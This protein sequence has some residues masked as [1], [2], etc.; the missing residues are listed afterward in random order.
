[1]QVFKSTA[2]VR[3][4]K[5]IAAT[6]SSARILDLHALA[7]E[8]PEDPDYLESPLFLHP[9][10]NRSIIVKHNLGSDEDDRSG[11][12]RF[13]ATKVIFPFDQSDL[14]LGGQ[15]LIVD[16]RD[17]I[18]ALTRH[19]DYSTLSLDRDLAVL[20]AVD[21]LPTL[22]P[23]LVREILNQHQIEVGRCYYRFSQCDK[24]QMLDFVANEIE[25][26]I[27]ACVGELKENDKRTQHLS[28]LLLADQGS[29]E[30]EPLRATFRMEPAQFSEAMF[31]W[32][33]FLYYRWRSRTLAPMLRRT[34]RSISQIQSRRYEHGDLS[35]IDRAK[36][37]LEKT[38]T[39]SWREVG[40]RLRLYDL[41][42]ASLTDQESADGFRS[43]LVH[44]SHLFLELGDRI[45]RLE[46]V[47]SFWD[48]R[49]GG[50]RFTDLAPDEVFDG[51][52]DL[53]Q[54]LSVR[55]GGEPTPLFAPEL[56]TA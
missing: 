52:R 17:F 46:Q 47:S 23:F 11:P 43:F 48:D 38:I 55:I 24:A 21:R 20:R 26:L 44:G 1:M 51:L 37:M 7:L 2:G 35:F 53:L 42:F 8:A 49:F 32:K 18:G 4:L 13:N 12:G 19:L 5:G 41:A 45:G 25:S 22:D 9:L 31:S 6:A 30:L 28:Q 3:S 33:A 15:F 36:R 14:D 56:Q 54:A 50:E 16:Q 29:P 10:L 27:R 34:L 40:Q 39:S